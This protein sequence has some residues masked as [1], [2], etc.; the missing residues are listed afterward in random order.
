VK[1]DQGTPTVTGLVQVDAL[2]VLVRQDDVREASPTTGPIVVK[3][4]PKSRGVVTSAPS[5]TLRRA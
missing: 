4:M 2:T 3:S 1:D 5:H